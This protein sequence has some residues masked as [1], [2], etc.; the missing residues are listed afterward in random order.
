VY[1]DVACSQLL[2]LLTKHLV[3]SG[4]QMLPLLELS[5]PS[6]HLSSHPLFHLLPLHLVLHLPVVLLILSLLGMF[7]LHH[8]NHVTIPTNGNVICMQIYGKYVFLQMVIPTD[9]HSCMLS[10][11]ICEITALTFA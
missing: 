2:L 5:P 8:I 10:F 6:S 7:S 11:S 3:Q 9:F 1:C 4:Q